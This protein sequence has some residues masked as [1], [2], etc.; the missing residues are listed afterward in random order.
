MTVD[1][2]PP[3]APAAPDRR[4]EDGVA[5][6][7]DPVL[8]FLLITG[9]VALAYGAGSIVAFWWFDALGIGPS[10][11]PPARVTLAA[12]VL[13]PKRDW[14]AVI[15]G[16][17]LAEGSIDRWQGLGILTPGYVLANTPGAM[18][19][20]SRVGSSRTMITG[21]SSQARPSLS[22][23]RRMTTSPVFQQRI[24]V[25]GSPSFIT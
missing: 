13:L 25:A 20:A 2:G 15:L 16:A 12:L 22:T 1:T 21:N 19:V 24:G 8:R 10:F 6:P 4:S 18:Y 14:V 17:A 11:Y 5:G 23:S 9:A 7:S 3:P